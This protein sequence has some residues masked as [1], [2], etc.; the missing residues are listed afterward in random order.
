[1]RW[2]ISLKRQPL[3]NA[4]NL[5]ALAFLVCGLTFG[6]ATTKPP[7]R[8]F[9][10]PG[11]DTTVAQIADSLSREIFI[12]WENE[13]LAK[14]KADSARVLLDLSTRLWQALAS[15]STLPHASEDDSIQAIIQYNEGVEKLNAAADTLLE[16]SDADGKERVRSLLLEAVQDL[17]AAIEL[18]PYDIEARFAL[19]TAYQYLA[20]RFLLDHYWGRAAAVLQKLLLMDK[21][22]HVFYQLLGTCYQNLNQWEEMLKN[23]QQAEYVLRQT[24]PLE[25]PEHVEINDSTVASALDSTTLFLYV[26]NQMVAHMYLHN[27]DSARVVL[28]RA[29]R[30]AR[31]DDY[32]EAIQWFYNW[33]VWDDWNLAAS[34]MRDSLQVYVAR[35]EYERA[36]EGYKL[37]LKPGNLRTERARQEVKWLLANLEYASLQQHE[38]AIA[39]MKEIMDFYHQDSLGIAMAQQDTLLDRF[40][41]A[42]GIMCFNTA[43]EALKIPDRQ[44]AL[45]YFLQSAGV[46]WSQQAKAFLEISKLV[47]TDPGRSERFAKRA[48]EL[49]H[50]LEPEERKDNLRILVQVLRQRGKFDEARKYREE[51][52]GS[53]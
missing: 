38:V 36:A 50:Q 8:I 15:D 28:E 11:V 3:T 48:Y 18:N 49:R 2:K 19:S 51:L 4:L 14:R 17:E 27:E 40:I 41:D 25:V 33:A 5:S 32:R 47:I 13:Q 20:Q 43:L 10:Y 35:Q 6:C 7:Q 42:Y 39:R 21:G 9:V 26:Y 53:K 12:T 29:R 46:P 44:K 24:A 22:Q 1:M 31:T 16:Q 23:F 30:L 52:Y 45:A 37:L 34:E